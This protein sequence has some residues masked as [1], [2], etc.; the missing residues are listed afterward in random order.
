MNYWIRAYCIDIYA[1]N[2]QL[3]IVHVGRLKV[4]LCSL[5]NSIIYEI[6]LSLIDVIIT[7][8]NQP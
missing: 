7:S 5:E 4:R 2:G 3:C 1:M 6:V 8:Y